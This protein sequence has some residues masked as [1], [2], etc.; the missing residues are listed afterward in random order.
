MRLLPMQ[1]T[2]KQITTTIMYKFIIS[3]QSHFDAKIPGG[4]YQGYANLEKFAFFVGS[5]NLMGKLPPDDIPSFIPQGQ[6]DVYAVGTQECETTI[7]QSFVFRSKDGWEAKLKNCI[8]PGYVLLRAHILMA[9][10]LAV[11]V[12]EEMVPCISHV[13]SSDVATGLFNSIGNKGGIGI[14][15]KFCSTSFSFVCAHFQ[16]FQNNVE[17]RNNDFHRIHNGLSLSPS[18]E[19]SICTEGLVNRFDRVFW[20]GDLNYRINGTRR[21]IDNVIAKKMFEV[22][23]ANDQLLIERAAGRVFQGFREG[24]LTFLPTYKFDPN[25]DMYDTSE[26]QRIPSWTDRI[27]YRDDPEEIGLLMYDACTEYK[28]SD[29]RPVHAAFLVSID[30]QEEDL[31][32]V[33]QKLQGT[34]LE[35]TG[36][37][38][39][40]QAASGPDPDSLED[41]TLDP[42]QKR[43]V[44]RYRNNRQTSAS[45][46]ADST[47][48]A[49][50]GSKTGEP[51]PSPK[52]PESSNNDDF[53]P[54]DSRGESRGESGRNNTCLDSKQGVATDTKDQGDDRSAS[55]ENDPQSGA[56]QKQI[57]GGSRHDLSLS[58][59]LSSNQQAVTGDLG[60]T[61]NGGGE[62]V[63]GRNDGGGDGGVSRDEK[64][65]SDP[66]ASSDIH[67]SSIHSPTDMQGDGGTSRSPQRNGNSGGASGV[68]DNVLKQ[69]GSEARDVPEQNPPAKRR[70]GSINQRNSSS[71]KSKRPSEVCVIS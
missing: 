52:R 60:G 19:E 67:R 54:S 34:G 9:I 14:S 10:H 68:D 35:P 71:G 40:H 33:S 21:A 20:C 24:R 58:S 47:P 5:W 61:S 15:F 2:F 22:L 38:V 26:K 36:Q 50:D 49:I 53:D 44:E 23:H 12:R 27:L 6:Y 18:G 28:V 42:D 1:L 56:T 39:V 17:A 3:T 43:D 59:L 30:V 55:P 11:F 70:S 45:P 41:P 13:M 64:D 65:A 46:E 8:G 16:A 66:C 4:L 37:V 7:A 69:P 62:S 48:S 25:T 32:L 29:H 51:V 63:T 31:R 57:E